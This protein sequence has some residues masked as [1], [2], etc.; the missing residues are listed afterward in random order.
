MNDLQAY[1]NIF[2]DIRPWSGQLP[3]GYTVDFIGALTNLRFRTVFSVDP[4]LVGGKYVQTRL[5]TLSDGEGWFETVNWIEAA[6]P[7]RDRFVMITLGACCGAQAIVCYRALQLLIPMPSKFVAVEGDS[8]NV[9]WMEIHMRDNGMDPEAHC[10]L[11]EAA[12]SDR[13]APCYS[14]LAGR[15]PEFKIA[16]RPTRTLHGKNMPSRSFPAASQKKRSAIF[17]LRTPPAS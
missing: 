6:R 12:I 8:E 4:V 9:P 7:A 15:V 2:A 16:T 14:P 1:A 10:W 5:P 17:C 13:K 11:V 3:A